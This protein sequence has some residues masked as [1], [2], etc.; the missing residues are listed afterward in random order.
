MSGPPNRPKIYLHQHYE[1]A[2]VY[3]EY[4]VQ[5]FKQNVYGEGNGDNISLS[6]ALGYGHITVYRSPSVIRLVFGTG[7]L[8]MISDCVQTKQPD[9]LRGQDFS[10]FHQIRSGPHLAFSPMNTECYF[11][12]C[13]VVIA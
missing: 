9:S 2:V 5:Y 6:H 7:Y 13:K 1:E 11:P 12:Q 8:N 4:Q 3:R 10:P